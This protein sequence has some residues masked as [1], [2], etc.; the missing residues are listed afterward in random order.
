[1]IESNIFR[2]GFVV[3]KLISVTNG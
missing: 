1:M 2:F 3:I